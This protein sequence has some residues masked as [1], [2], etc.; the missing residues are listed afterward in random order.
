H[1]PPLPS[2]ERG[3]VF[4]GLSAIVECFTGPSDYQLGV[5]ELVRVRTLPTS[6]E[7]SYTERPTDFENQTLGGGS[8]VVRPEFSLAALA[9]EY[10]PRP[11]RVD[12]LHLS[13]LVLVGEV[14]ATWAGE[15]LLCGPFGQ[16]LTSELVGDLPDHPLRFWRRVLGCEPCRLDHGLGGRER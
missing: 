2:G 11:V 12:H 5:A 8:N 4:G 16:G 7:L 6:H 10:G 13:I 1:F 3:V 15:P 14:P 9:D